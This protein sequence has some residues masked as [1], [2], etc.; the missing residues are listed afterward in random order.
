MVES[1]KMYVREANRFSSADWRRLLNAA[2]MEMQQQT[3]ILVGD[4]DVPLVAGTRLYDVASVGLYR[5]SGAATIGGTRLTLADHGLLSKTS[6]LTTA[7]FPTHVYFARTGRIGLYPVPDLTADGSTLVLHGYYSPAE[8]TAL[9]PET[10]EPSFDPIDH[11]TMV[12]GA[13]VQAERIDKNLDISQLTRQQYSDGVSSMRSRAQNRVTGGR[14][15][16]PMGRR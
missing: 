6:E 7:G 15:V 14:V 3:R 13:V 5:L 10:F 2:Q 12:L 1:C 4:F 8:I 9:T 16:A 11:P